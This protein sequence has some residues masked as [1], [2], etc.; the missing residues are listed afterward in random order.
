MKSPHF[1][2]NMTSCL[3]LGFAASSC[4]VAGQFIYLTYATPQLK[5]PPKTGHEFCKEG[6]LVEIDRRYRNKLGG[7][8]LHN[9]GPNDEIHVAFIGD[10][11]I[12][13]LGS[14]CH[15]ASLGGQTAS[16]LARLFKKP[17]RYWSFGKAGLTAGEIEREMIP[18][19]KD[20][21]NSNRFDLVVISCGTNNVIRGQ[22][23]SLFRSEFDSLLQSIRS[24]RLGDIPFITLG[25]FDLSQIPLLQFP[26]NHLLGYRSRKIQKEIEGVLEQMCEQTTMAITKMPSIERLSSNA[27]N[28][29]LEDTPSQVRA[30]LSYDDFFAEDG[31]HPAKFG[32]AFLGCQIA[33]LFK[34]IVV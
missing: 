2:D 27:D 1:Y 23:A 26:V 25:L 17:V 30:N 7:N 33:K 24:C 5:S 15:E 8:D 29:L 18:L 6:I 31:F 21:A 20:T 11:I 28:F 19:L 14:E 10:S 4:I 32:T 13:G 12:A 16:A 34:E 9:D 3:T 22:S